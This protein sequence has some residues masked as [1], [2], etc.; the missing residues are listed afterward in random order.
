MKYL[1]KIF[2]DENRDLVEW[3]NKVQENGLSIKVMGGDHQ[4]LL[5]LI[6]Q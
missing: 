3:Y 5:K 2:E 4:F 1:R 6:N